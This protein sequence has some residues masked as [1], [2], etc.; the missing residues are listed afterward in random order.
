MIFAVIGFAVWS[1]YP[2][3][4]KIK[5]GLDLRGGIHLVMRVHTDDA[6]KAELDQV[7][8]RLRADL[9]SGEISHQGLDRPSLTEIG[10]R[11][12]DPGQAPA[13]RELL[14]D[15]YGE[16]DLDER[17]ADWILSL[18]SQVVDSIRELAI[19]QVLETIR[20]RV[21]QYGVLE[22]VIQRQ[23][24]SGGEKILIQLP[25]MENPEQVKDV[26]TTPAFLEWKL[27][28]MP[29][30]FT[31]DDFRQVVPDTETGVQDLFGGTLPEDTAIFP[32]PP[33]GSDGTTAIRYWPLRKVSAVTGI[34]LKNARRG[35]DQ[36][37]APVVEFTLT[38][39]AGKRFEK[40]TRENQGQILAILLDGKII[41]V[42]RI[43]AT[44][45]DQGIIEGGFSLEQAQVLVLQ[46]RSGALP[47]TIEILEERTVGPSLGSDSIRKGVKAA[48]FGSFFVVLFMLVYY[49]LSGVIAVIALGLNLVLLLGAMAYLG[50]TLTLPGIA[51]ITL[52][53]GMAVDANVLVFERIRE[54]R[55][56]GRTVRSAISGG[57]SKAFSTIID[58]NV[59]T[60]IAA[61]FLYGYGTGPV[62]GFAVT[63]II[64]I[65]ASMFTALFVSRAIFD[66]QLSRRKGRMDRLSI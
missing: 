63:L 16:W 48:L 9:K 49:R 6:V 52:T 34:D 59:T 64:G 35:Q 66:F 18:N 56:L 15:Q 47:A 14:K 45:R 26:F 55:R 29:P 19:Q 20:K 5:L 44:I 13:V 32:K 50:A 58:A 17:G 3:R 7:T 27:A 36:F 33:D 10:I 39:D 38:A 25:G 53:I 41:S 65:L 1:A 21:D 31:P 62:K 8:E 42:P 57:F 46:L 12:I 61:L 11:E 54:E 2:L 28:V 43:N 40:L 4:D 22:P 30:D 24:I 37:G 60:W 51:G 23:G